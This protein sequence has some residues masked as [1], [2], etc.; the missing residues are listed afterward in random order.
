MYIFLSHGV[1]FWMFF[2]GRRKLSKPW[3]ITMRTE[4]SQNIWIQLSQYA[5]HLNYLEKIPWW[6]MNSRKSKQ[7][8]PL[9]AKWHP[10]LGGQVFT[11]R[12]E[13]GS[14]CVS[15]SRSPSSR[16]GQEMDLCTFDFKPLCTAYLIYGYLGRIVRPRNDCFIFLTYT[17]SLDLNKVFDAIGSKFNFFPCGRHI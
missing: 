17:R 8:S 4:M 16:N 12:R 13:T 15:S 11:R 9:I 6:N 7:L 5:D 2:E 10:T 3:R 1:T 14:E